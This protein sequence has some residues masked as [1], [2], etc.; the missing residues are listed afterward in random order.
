MLVVLVIQYICLYGRTYKHTYWT[1]KGC[2]K[3]YI[4]V[5]AKTKDLNNKLEK[6][7]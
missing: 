6:C 2:K 5:C 3:N 1:S 4:N 7:R